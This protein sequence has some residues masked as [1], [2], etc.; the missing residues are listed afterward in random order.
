MPPMMSKSTHYIIKMHGYYALYVN[1]QFYGSYDTMKE[2][3]DDLNE[4]M[5]NDKNDAE[6][7]YD[8]MSS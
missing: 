8:S 6:P 3:E 4:L 1:S 2:L 7:L 5:E